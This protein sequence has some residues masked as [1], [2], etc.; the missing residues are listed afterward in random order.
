MQESVNGEYLLVS[1]IP[2]VVEGDEIWSDPLWTKDLEPHFGYLEG[3]TLACPV[4]RG[5]ST[6]GMRRI[7]PGLRRRI[8]LEHLPEFESWRGKFLNWPSFW[9]R[10]FRLVR[11]AGI[12]HFTV[13]A[14]PIFYGM[15][16]PFLRRR[17]RIGLFG[18][19]DGSFWRR[20]ARTWFGK[21]VADQAERGAKA[22]CCNAH[23]TV[24]THEQYIRQ[25]T[26]PRNVN[27]LVPAVWLDESSFLPA[28]RVEP[29]LEAK[30]ATLREGF[31]VAFLG[32]L[33]PEKGPDVL[34]EA[35]RI[36]SGRGVAL[37]ADIF[38]EGPFLPQLREM[39]AEVPSVRFR[40]LIAY[41]PEFHREVAGYHAVALP[42]RS[43]EHQRVIFDCMSQAVP[44]LASLSPGLDR[45][46]DG[47]VGLRFPIDDAAALAD[48]I[49][50]LIRDPELFL[51]IS[52][53]AYVATG[54]FT[55]AKMHKDRGDL[56]RQV[57][58][59]R[60]GIR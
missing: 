50:R 30:V 49:E 51:R 37:Q 47:K 23:A 13:C 21:V 32:R 39:A 15:V 25:L 26:D 12:L 24:S 9:F 5:G 58:G 44:I 55:H 56:L 27:Q 14:Y 57:F 2:V 7:D 16:V 33:I 8:R 22:A 36:L 10:F 46:E 52:R 31:R 6:E 41:G 28:D 43:D 53:Q 59:N 60:A 40:G 17:G 48:R 4:V 29:A 38:G 11:R 54:N 35:A 1:T 42:A 34:I 45:V 3:I 20:N 18:V 19:I